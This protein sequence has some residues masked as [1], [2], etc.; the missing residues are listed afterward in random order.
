MSAQPFT[1]LTPEHYLEID[2][3]AGRKSEYYRD[4]MHAMAG[5][6][7]NHGLIVLNAGAEIRQAV[8][9]RPCSVTPADVRLRVAETG[10]Y[11]YP[12]LMVVCGDPVFAD[13]RA[14]H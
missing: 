12:D 8:G 14:E 1:P 11:T 4:A 13:N 6:T 9:D 5:E 10:L 3:K 7:Y 2:R